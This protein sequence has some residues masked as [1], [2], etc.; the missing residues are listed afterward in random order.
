MVRRFSKTVCLG[1]VHE[2]KSWLIWMVV[3]MSSVILSGCG[4][5]DQSD[6]S[7]TDEPDNQ[8]EVL[9]VAPDV[10]VAFDASDTP[11][12]MK[13]ISSRWPA[14]PSIMGKA[15][16]GIILHLDICCSSA[17]VIRYTIST[18][19][20]CPKG[21]PIAGSMWNSMT[22]GIIWIVCTMTG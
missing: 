13:T 15:P 20:F 17:P 14:I 2:Q 6:L 22:A 3:V 8:T 1:G 7:V 19:P 16:A 5:S 9:S 18:E 21:I 10:S 11:D 12:E 4:K